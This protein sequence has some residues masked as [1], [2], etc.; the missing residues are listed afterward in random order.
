MAQPGRIQHEYPTHTYNHTR[1]EDFCIRVFTLLPGN[2]YSELQAT[3]DT[4]ALQQ[5]K[6]EPTKGYEAVSYAWGS[7]TLSRSLKTPKGRI[8]IPRS[9]FV[10][11]QYLR[12]AHQPRRLWADC[13]CISQTDVEERNKQ[14]AMMPD[15]FGSALKVLVWLGP[16][17]PDDA[18]AFAMLGYEEQMPHWLRG[19]E[20]PIPFLDHALQERPWCSCCKVQFSVQNSLG[21]ASLIAAKRLL[22][23]AWFTRVWTLQEVCGPLARVTVHSGNHITSIKSLRNSF[24][25]LHDIQRVTERRHITNDEFERIGLLHEVSDVYLADQRLKRPEDTIGVMIRLTG[26]NCYD[27]RDRIF[28]VRG[29][30]GIQDVPL[31]RPDY[32]SNAALV[33]RRFVAHILL[34]SFHQNRQPSEEDRD[35]HA[36][37]ILGLC[38]ATCHDDNSRWEWPSWVPNF[39][40]LSLQADRKRLLYDNATYMEVGCQPELWPFSRSSMRFKSVPT[41]E[42]SCT[43]RLKGRVFGK[44]KVVLERSSFPKKVADLGINTPDYGS[45][46]LKVL[47]RLVKWHQ[48]VCAFLQTHLDGRDMYCRES[49]GLVR[50]YL[51]CG[52]HSGE[53]PAEKLRAVRLL[54]S[55]LQATSHGEPYVDANRLHYRLA[56]VI[57]R[58]YF[59]FAH[60]DRIAAIIE[61][62][63]S[64]KKL[65][66]VPAS[67]SEGDH[68]CICP[69]APFPFVLRA[70]EDGM[71]RLQGDFWIHDISE[72]E[73]IGA[74]TTMTEMYELLGSRHKSWSRWWTGAMPEG[75]DFTR[76]DSAED[77]AALEWE[78][79]NVGDILLC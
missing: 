5:V 77:T 29:L 68:V 38:S 22:H 71:Y 33:Y 19:V 39:H 51:A 20:D 60:F 75:M 37:V 54:E 65:A 72:V 56:P 64:R 10:A 11:L 24:H 74:P 61:M 31:L 49:D 36:A 57:S 78:E 59:R 6:K 43:L 28:A 42:D 15:I 52:V 40:I 35:L 23:R 16:S 14:V 25:R 76:S 3:L 50:S 26:R 18:L 73:A 46:D 53:S 30:L 2:Y 7:S 69:G 48:D 9:L 47:S 58:N 27:P 67:S 63:N 55:C 21:R 12:H 17:Q 45:A 34:T 70:A 32:T 44:V 41:S 8:L 13:V 66:W 62:P 4:V 1:L 79:A